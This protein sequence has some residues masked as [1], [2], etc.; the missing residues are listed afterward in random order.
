VQIEKDS[1]DFTIFSVVTVQIERDSAIARPKLQLAQK[2]LADL[3]LS[4][5]AILRLPASFAYTSTKPKNV[6]L[7]ITFLLF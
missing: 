6:S 2:I 5:I 3:R 1:G 7:I 4:G